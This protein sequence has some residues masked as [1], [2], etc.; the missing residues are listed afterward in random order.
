VRTWAVIVAGGSGERFGRHGGKQLA[1][2]SGRPI[3]AIALD[4]FQAAKAI[5]AV[6][7]V[8]HPERV[9]EYGA[10]CV[11]AGNPGKVRK[12]V[13]GGATRQSSVAAGLAAVPIDVDAV[14]VHDGARP[15][16]S[17]A[18]VDS[19]VA[20]LA[21]D[22]ALAAVVVGH[23]VHDTLKRVADDGVT[24][25]GTTDR[26]RLWVAQTP[27]VLRTDALRAAL[28]AAD[29]DGFTG[30]DDASLVERSG[31]VVRMVIGPRTNIKVTVPEDL[32]IVSA[33]LADRGRDADE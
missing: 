3:L 29:A 26:S 16:V 1:E 19:A 27:Q 7:L 21:A 10:A 33:L 8:V 32:R 24:V 9:D 22:P 23:P 12:V 15:L 18:V 28:A 13:A 31:G 4:A 30:T 25:V 20:A 11:D 6:V 14:A 5:E 17:A 2:A